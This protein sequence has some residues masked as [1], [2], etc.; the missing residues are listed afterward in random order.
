MTCEH[1]DFSATVGVH[2][3]SDTE[4]GPITKWSAE[5]NIT[6]AKCSA[7]FE[8]LG[9]QPGYDSQGARV[10]L[11]GKQA[12]LAISPPGMKPNPFQRLQFG[13]DKVV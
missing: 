8:F 10:T 4:G 6:C 11:D 9:L 13:I 1:E 2:R 12:I 7:E 3:L 5:V